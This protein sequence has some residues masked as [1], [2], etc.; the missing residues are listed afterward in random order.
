MVSFVQLFLGASLFQALAI[1]QTNQTCATS[2]AGNTIAQ[3]FLNEVSGAVNATYVVVPID[4]NLA[5]SIIPSQYGIL[6]D[7]IKKALP[8]LPEGTFPVKSLSDQPI[9]SKILTLL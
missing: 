1:A 4:Y 6:Y 3:D 2:D 9:S 8:T 7:Q 5:R